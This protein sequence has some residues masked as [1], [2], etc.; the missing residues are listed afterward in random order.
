M[1][2]KKLSKL[3]I[4]FLS[5]LC[6]SLNVSAQNQNDSVLIKNRAKMTITKM[7]TKVS[8]TKEQKRQLKDLV[9]KRTELK[10]QMRRL[11]SKNDE[12]KLIMEDYLAVKEQI[13]QVMTDDQLEVLKEKSRKKPGDKTN[14]PKNNSNTK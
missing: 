7:E 10:A 9:Y 5:I 3:L 8:L 14:Q 13:D 4:L 11:D 6:F 2:T 12:Y 1:K